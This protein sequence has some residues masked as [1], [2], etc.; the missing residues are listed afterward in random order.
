MRRRL[1]EGEWKNLLEKFERCGLTRE[2]FCEQHDL[3][4]ATFSLWRRKLRSEVLP[5][6]ATFVELAIPSQPSEVDATHP[7]ELVVELPYGV[8]L[9]FRGMRA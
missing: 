7:G 1:T 5:I 3:A 8:V 4:L 9:R 2:Q 6:P